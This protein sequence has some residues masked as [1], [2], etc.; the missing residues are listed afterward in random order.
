MSFS[1]SQTKPA[2]QRPLLFPGI[3]LWALGFMTFTGSVNAHDAGVTHAQVHLAS[4]SVSGG[5]NHKQKSKVAGTV[6]LNTA[7]AEELAAALKGVGLS[8]ARAIVR[9]RTEIGPFRDIQELEEVKGIGPRT[10]ARNKDRITLRKVK[11]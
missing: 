2:W 4:K 9:Y 10:V 3:L 1:L 11:G 5:S 7:T 6:D 8:K